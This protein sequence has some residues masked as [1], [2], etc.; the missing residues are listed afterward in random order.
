ML[1]RWCAGCHCAHAADGRSGCV[2]H[3]TCVPMLSQLRVELPCSSDPSRATGAI[4]GPAATLP[5]ERGPQTAARS[6]SKPYRQRTRASNYLFWC[7]DAPCLESTFGCRMSRPGASPPAAPRAVSCLA[8]PQGCEP[9]WLPSRIR[10]SWRAARAALAA[11]WRPQ[12]RLAWRYML[13]NA[14][15]SA[16]VQR[17]SRA[18]NTKIRRFVWVEQLLMQPQRSRRH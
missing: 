17:R 3:A 2:S 6:T 7:R 1:M 8:S 18:Y 5:A 11:R 15:L 14:T 13:A 9:Y 4:A 16:T 10:V 12:R